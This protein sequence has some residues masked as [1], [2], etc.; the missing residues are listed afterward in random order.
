MTEL[1]R[2][3]WLTAAVAAPVAGALAGCDDDE[4]APTVSGVRLI[5]QL[6]LADVDHDGPFVELGSVTKDRH[7]LGGW[8]TG[9]GDDVTHDDVAATLVTASP[10]LVLLD[11][12]SRSGPWELTVRAR[13][14]GRR[15]LSLAVGDVALGRHALSGDGWTD[16]TV[17]LPMGAAR[18]GP[19]T[20]Q[21]IH[22]GEPGEPALA[23]AR[24]WVRRVGAPSEP[25]SLRELTRIAR[26]IT[27]RPPTRV[28]FRIDLRRARRLVTRARLRSGRTATLYAW[29]TEVG[30]PRVVAERRLAP[31]EPA[32]IEARLS[33]DGLGGLTLGVE[34][35]DPRAEVVLEDPRL[36]E[37]D[38]RDRKIRCTKPARHVLV[39]LCDTLRADRLRAY[40]PSTRVHAPALAAFA[41]EAAVFERCVTPA[42]WTKPSVGSLLTGRVPARHGALGPDDPLPA[43]VPMISERFRDAGFVT[44][45]FVAN[46][47]ISRELGFDRGW[48]QFTNYI[49]EDRRN[50]A[51]H[52]LEDAR[53]WIEAHRDERSFV[54]VH[55]VDPHVPYHPP[56]WDL[57]RYDAA[58]YE[59]PV[60]PPQTG[61]LLDAIR[62]GAVTLGPRDRRRLTAL[63]D[64]E[65]TYFDRFFGQFIDA[66]R[67][68]GWLDEA[69]TVFVAD[70]GEE[71]FDHG[72]V[73]HG[74]S[75]YEELLH[76]PL[77]VRPPGP[78]R[79]RP[80]LPQLVSLMD[81]TP[82]L[83][84]ATGLATPPGLDG[85]GLWR[86]LHGDPPPPE[87]AAYSMQWG[88]AAGD[89]LKWA[90][91]LGDHKLSM[92]GPLQSALFD[93]ARDPGETAPIDD[94]RA[95]RMLTAWLGAYLGAIA[96]AGRVHPRAPA[97]P[98]SA[99]L[100]AQ[101]RALG[102]VDVERCAD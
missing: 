79:A 81:L 46:G 87:A 42:N 25:P 93:L 32:W 33:G 40:A 80:R 90:A 24:V 56:R 36:D 66:L 102:Y 31:G 6:P 43:S 92:L 100:C 15:H 61:H 97:A 88:P 16:V 8:R 58:P 60:D 86:E 12:P 48:D 78:A 45:A 76:V 98:L 18:P 91:R 82:T 69:L 55:C 37:A 67:E 52:V 13:P 68:L 49:T 7:T 29:Q 11:F 21:I 72:D 71:L 22:D 35:D 89:E 28:T 41:D 27:L 62:E 95:H 14:A 84:E 30:E 94:P 83:C 39:V 59:G 17:R 101:L 99:E 70:H 64:G 85:Y 1:T 23:I 20:L 73:G 75:L 10:A 63:Y 57:E 44:A 50:R 65:V 47:F 51:N 19:W 53:A 9:W 77:M 54:Y 2:R 5:S 74:H 34:S 38:R 4:P 3:Q 96:R 26:A